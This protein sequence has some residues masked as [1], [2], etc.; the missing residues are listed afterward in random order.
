MP[1][2]VMGAFLAAV[3]AAL[4]ASSNATSDVLLIAA[5]GIVWLQL[6]IEA[7][8]LPMATA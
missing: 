2:E 1:H 7:Q 8:Q 4:R 3:V 5:F 6:H